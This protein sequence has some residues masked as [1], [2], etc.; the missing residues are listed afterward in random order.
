MKIFEIK[1]DYLKELNLQF[2]RIKLSEPLLPWPSFYCNY[3]FDIFKFEGACITN[4][5][6]RKINIHFNMS[7]GGD[8]L[9]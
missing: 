9:K 5:A 4:A 1:P 8:I 7:Y 3:N 2:K 6:M